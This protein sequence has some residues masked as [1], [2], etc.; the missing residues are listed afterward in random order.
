M[1]VEDRHPGPNF[2]SDRTAGAGTAV[3]RWI[4]VSLVL[5]FLLH[6]LGLLLDHRL[7]AWTWAHEPLHSFMETAGACIGIVVACMLLV[8]QRL[9]RGTS[10][11]AVIAAGLIA[12]SILDGLHAL[13]EVGQN[14]VWLHSV[15]TFAGGAVCAF[16]WL[17]GDRPQRAAT[18]LTVAGCMVSAVVIVTFARPA[19]LPLMVNA[20]GFTNVA[21]FLNVGGGVL[22]TAAAV[23]QYLDFRQRGRVDD[24]LFATHFLLLGGAAVMFEQSQLW[25]FSW[26]WWHGLRLAAYLVAMAFGVASIVNLIQ[27]INKYQQDLGIAN[28]KLKQKAEDASHRLRGILSILDEH[29]LYSMADTSG[30][31]IEV[32]EG[33]CRVS[34]YSRDELLGQDHRILNSGVHPREFWT[35]MYRKL[36]SGTHWRQDVCNRAK[37]GSLYWVDSCNVPVLD[38]NGKPEAYFSLRIDITEKKEYEDQL[39][40]STL[41]SNLLCRV[42]TIASEAESIDDALSATIDAVCDGFGW[43]GG[44]AY[45]M[46]IPEDRRSS[47]RV[48]DAARVIVRAVD[49][50]DSREQAASGADLPNIVKQVCRSGVVEW[51]DHEVE[52]RIT[53]GRANPADEQVIPG[54]G[55]VQQIAVP[56]YLKGRVKAVLMFQGG[57]SPDTGARLHETLDGVGR[58]LN[59]LL[60]RNEALQAASHA[61]DRFERAIAGT[62]DGLWEFE[63]ES[64]KAWYAD[65]FKN[66]LGLQPFEYDT[67]PNRMESW[68]A[69]IHAH[70]LDQFRWML[71]PNLDG[72]S[73]FDIK[74]RA[75]LANG[76]F[77]W[78][79]S[80]GQVFRDERGNPI[81]VAGS[82]S[83]IHEQ[84]SAESR[85]SLAAAAANTGLWDWD[86]T[87]KTFVSDETLHRLLGEVPLKGPLPESYFFTKVH[88]DDL[89]RLQAAVEEAMAS[90]DVMLD[91]T[92]RVRCGDGRYKWIRTSGRVI[93][94]DEEG[95]PTRM[96]GQHMD[97]DSATR[98]SRGFERLALVE[99]T[100]CESESISALCQA[101]AE[102][103]DVAYVGV[104]RVN[105]DDAG[106]RN[107]RVVGGFKN[108]QPLAPGP[109]HIDISPCKVIQEQPYCLFP[110]GAA[111]RFP[112]DCLLSELKAEGYVG[113]LL[114]DSKNRI[115]GLLEIVHSDSIPDALREQPIIQLFGTRAAGE[116]E[117]FDIESGLRKALEASKA[118]N[119]AKSEFLANMSHEIRTPMTAILGHSDLL[120]ED[121]EEE[122]LS[123]EELLPLKTIQR[124]GHHLLGVINDILDL[125]KIEAGKMAIESA[126]CAPLEMVDEIE[127]LMKVRADEQGIY[128]RTVVAGP[129]PALI[130]SDPLRLRQ[131]LINL[132]G[133]AV[134]FTREGGVTLVVRFTDLPDPMLQFDIIDTGIGMT[135]E[136]VDVLFAPFM[137]ADTSMARQFGGTGLGLTIS[138]RLAQMLGG[139]VSVV[140]TKPDRGTT[141]RVTIDPGSL[142]GVEMINPA[143]K[144]SKT[145]PSAPTSSASPISPGPPKS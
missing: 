92:I 133:N 95:R 4:M 141:I 138:L 120:V 116:L 40:A 50:A 60:E 9:D 115:L 93:E 80:R 5:S 51:I 90:D 97:A 143:G 121:A 76:S 13:V 99:R 47:S 81:H 27:Q 122:G 126:A 43:K 130:H 88:A 55:K 72:R 42:I 75:K 67:F 144:A 25:D 61:Q 31:I 140:D 36:A 49:S 96:I 10:R 52:P 139:T 109:R 38:K 108:G 26:W 135:P 114:Q 134:K 79:R 106:S 59:Q 11:N 136:K 94:R 68:Y 83:D 107:A 137:Q 22:L 56:I 101:I 16:V 2:L 117:R 54:F 3:A 119:E 48:P 20:D 46:E 112:N 127:S 89:P 53:D 123:E 6:A 1:P 84:H 28:E 33:F 58:Q 35:D 125:S 77:R 128:F 129:V 24:L 104:V 19:W 32:N 142:D 12:M 21:I 14:F 132:V 102:S 65:Q 113:V 41:R 100:A 111:K 131:I 15:A 110:E 7:D 103:F 29:T 44:H 17:P 98:L 18:W 8:M 82:I 71:D 39:C 62:S 85:T 63:P 87:Q 86:V 34:G 57:G 78:F 74:H 91:Q 66:L 145:A 23:R 30:K 105:V 64:E 118:A 69:R 70:D 124:N 37:N 45:I 73:Q